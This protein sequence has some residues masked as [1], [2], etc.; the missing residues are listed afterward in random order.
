MPGVTKRD[1]KDDTDSVS[2]SS[3]SSVCCPCSEYRIAGSIR[4][5]ETDYYYPYLGLSLYPYGLPLFSPLL[6]LTGICGCPSL[7]TN[8][9]RVGYPWC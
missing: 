9:N 5:C 6:R 8:I 2:P 3:L 4:Q 1:H 7:R